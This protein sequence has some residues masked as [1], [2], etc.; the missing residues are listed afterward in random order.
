[1]SKKTKTRREGQPRISESQL[2]A[3]RARRTAA[4]AVV[5]TDSESAPGAPEA[6]TIR[7]PWGR[8]DEEYAMIRSD[9][10]RLI[11]IAAVLLALIVALSFVL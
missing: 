7:S 1:M 5:E 4:L 9:L 8:V 3:Y 6:T 10:I 11:V 2:Q